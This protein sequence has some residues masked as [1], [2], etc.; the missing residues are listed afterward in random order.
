VI[1]VF[2]DERTLERTQEAINGV[3]SEEELEEGLRKENRKGL[4]VNDPRTP[5]ARI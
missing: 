4:S 5:P 1:D 2:A 3:F